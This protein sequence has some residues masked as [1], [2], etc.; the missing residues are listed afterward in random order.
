MAIS[1]K[2][3]NELVI[4]GVTAGIVYAIFSNG[5]PN[6]ADVRADE[7]ST[8]PGSTC[9]NTYKTVNTATLTAAAVV[10]GVALLSRSKTVFVVGG[11]MTLIEAW[12]YHFHNFGTSRS[13]ESAKIA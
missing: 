4:S 3:E 13:M 12:K 11:A 6:L 2:P 10:T 8:T 9:M 5:V 7:M 1:L